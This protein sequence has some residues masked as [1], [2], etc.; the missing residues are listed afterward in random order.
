M[1]A[2]DLGSIASAVVA[3]VA[4]ILAWVSLHKTNKFNERQNQ[5]AETT[6]RLNQMLIDRETAEGIAAKRADLS[7]NLIEVG[8]N[9]HRLKVFNR[10]RGTARNVRLTVLD[11]DDEG[12]FL[13]ANDVAAKFP[14]PI[15]E[16]HQAVELIAALHFGSRMR[17]H[18]KLVWDDDTGSNHEKELTPSL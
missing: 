7:A 2:G 13:I 3:F 17:A 8:R 5:L 9:K 1:T 16:Q 14:V 15:M 12:S 6:D 10:G 11:D 18:I 4:L